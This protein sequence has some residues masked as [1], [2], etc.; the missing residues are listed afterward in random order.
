MADDRTY[1]W[2]VRAGAVALRLWGHRVEVVGAEHLPATGPAVLAVNHISFL[3]F[4][5]AGYVGRRRGRHVRFLAKRS[6]FDLPV[7]GTLLRRMRHVPVDRSLG[8]V[9]YRRASRLLDAGEV[10]GLFPE[11]TISRS[12]LVKRPLRPGAAGLA[13]RTGAPLIPVAIW[14]AHRILTVDGRRTARRRVPVTILVGSPLTPVPGESPADLTERLHTTLAALVERAVDTYPDR[15][16]EHAGAWWLPASRG[17]R[18][19]GPA[20]AHA[21][22]VA[23]V[24]RLGDSLE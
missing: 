24:A 13:I 16:S 8:A 15:P 19:P 23:A 4:V 17:G 21:L 9:A 6:L 7:A 5:F 18:A 3:D 2:V 14:G 12:W 20:E 11:A 22:D 1:R 10:V